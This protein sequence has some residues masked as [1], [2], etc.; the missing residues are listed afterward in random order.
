[1][2]NINKVWSNNKF[3]GFFSYYSTKTQESKVGDIM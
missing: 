3:K 2:L 1:M